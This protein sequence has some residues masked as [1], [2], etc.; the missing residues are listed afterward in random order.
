MATK[1]TSI[2]PRLEKLLTQVGENL[3]LARLR[4]RLSAQQV[5]ERA[6]IT[7]TTLWQVEKGAPHV[8]MGTYAQV[9][10]VLGMEKDLL[11]LAT[12]DDLGRRLQ[13][14]QLITRK[15]APKSK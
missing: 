10:L 9:L 12:D 6:G 3:K 5:A 8:S 1:S 7:R 2:L 15:R 4:R 11:E 14:A 13:D